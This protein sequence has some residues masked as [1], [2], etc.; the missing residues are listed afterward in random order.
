MEQLSTFAS[1]RPVDPDRKFRITTITDAQAWFISWVTDVLVY[2]IVLNLFSEFVESIHIGAFWISILTAILFKILLVILG[3]AE[4]SVHHHFEERGA[5]TLALVG[6][7]L[8]IFFGK[9]AIIEFINWTFDE[10][11][12]HG[13]GAEIAMILT[14][15]IVSGLVWTIFEKLGTDVK[16]QPRASK[17]EE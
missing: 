17:H 11:E 15:I 12:F 9:L 13:L 8:V 1:R 7:L 4:H 16:L 3:K 2:I 14:M 10:V 6:A 5:E